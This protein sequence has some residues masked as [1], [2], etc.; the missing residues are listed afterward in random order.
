MK[1]TEDEMIGKIVKQGK[2][3]RRVCLPPYEYEFTCISCR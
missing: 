2:H 1:L 3:C